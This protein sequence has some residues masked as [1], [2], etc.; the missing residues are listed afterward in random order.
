ML[1]PTYLGC[2]RT[3]H[4]RTRKKE[5]YAVTQNAE[6]FRTTSKTA[7]WLVLSKQTMLLFSHR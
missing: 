1:F 6:I 5:T 7:A 3:A 2:T 4:A